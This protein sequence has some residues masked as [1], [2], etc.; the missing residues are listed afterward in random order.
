VYVEDLHT[1]SGTFV[2]DERIDAQLPHPVYEND[3][4]SF[5]SGTMT[6]ARTINSVQF[7]LVRT[8]T[9]TANQSAEL[10]SSSSHV[11]HAMTKN[12]LTVVI[13]DVTCSICQDVFV[14]PFSL[15]C[16]HTFCADCISKWFNSCRTSTIQCPLCRKDALRSP[17]HAREL[18]SLITKMI[19]PT[20]SSE[21]RVSRCTRREIIGNKMYVQKRCKN[22]MKRSSR[23]QRLTSMVEVYIQNARSALLAQ[24]QTADATAT[25][26]VPGTG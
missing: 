10:N 21:D 17:H 22:A 18:D 11:E 9:D 14:V 8:H 20:L 26:D 7:R 3:V 16:E 4:I 5:G 1:K 15:E 2:N 25:A 6:D 12:Q 19:E 23:T 13:D 24:S